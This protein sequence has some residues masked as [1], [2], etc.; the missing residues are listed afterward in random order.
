MPH[1]LL[2]C[3]RETCVCAADGFAAARRAQLASWGQPA[4]TAAVAGE[5]SVQGAGD[6]AAD[7]RSVGSGGGFH[8]LSV[9]TQLAA[10]I[11]ARSAHRDPRIAGP[12]AEYADLRP[13]EF[14]AHLLRRLDRDGRGRGLHRRIRPTPDRDDRSRQAAVDRRLLQQ[15]VSQGRGRSERKHRRRRRAVAHIEC[16]EVPAGVLHRAVHRL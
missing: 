7:Q 14:L 16:G 12:R 3:C 13:E 9:R 2:K 15:H 1:R 10:R 5:H 11:G 6:V 8:R 4:A